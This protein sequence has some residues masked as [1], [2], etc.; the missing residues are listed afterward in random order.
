MPTLRVG[1]VRR[2]ADFERLRR[3]YLGHESANPDWLRKWLPEDEARR[4]LVDLRYQAFY[5]Y[6]DL[7]ALMAR[8]RRNRPRVVTELRSLG[9]RRGRHRGSVHEERINSQIAIQQWRL[10]RGRRLPDMLWAQ[11][12]WHLGMVLTYW[13]LRSKR[14][15]T[16][17][18]GPV[19]A[20]ICQW[21]SIPEIGLLCTPNTIKGAHRYFVREQDGRLLYTPPDGQKPV[22]QC[23]SIRLDFVDS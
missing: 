1:S 14:D 17:L 12:C 13:V 2:R 22:C 5:D 20:R 8:L 6:I 3:K 23:P 7:A 21:F 4:D 15:R 19:L 10:K 9:G 18:P 16:R 11:F